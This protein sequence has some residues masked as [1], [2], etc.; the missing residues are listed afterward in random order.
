M[1]NN[2]LQWGGRFF[3][4]TL[5]I[6]L[7]SVDGGTGLRNDCFK[8][9]HLDAATNEMSKCDFSNYAFILFIVFRVMLKKYFNY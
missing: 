2:G 7:I 1:M 9:S 6:E 5:H 4:L 8:G 3:Y